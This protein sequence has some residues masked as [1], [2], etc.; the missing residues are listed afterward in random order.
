MLS[1]CTGQGEKVAENKK[2]SS[3]LYIQKGNSE[4]DLECTGQATEEGGESF[5]WRSLPK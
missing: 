4:E 2:G 3:H 5:A 1:V